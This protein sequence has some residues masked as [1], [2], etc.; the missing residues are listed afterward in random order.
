M[1][2]PVKNNRDRRIQKTQEL[3]RGALASL[4][5]EKPYDSIVVKEILDRANVGR[6][7]L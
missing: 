4:I 3:L 7:T 2:V 5:G 1:P 6:S